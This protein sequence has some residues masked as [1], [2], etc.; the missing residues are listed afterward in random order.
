MTVKK[1]S[2]KAV[3]DLIADLAGHDPGWQHVGKHVLL[4][5]RFSRIARP[6]RLD[7]LRGGDAG[8]TG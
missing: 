4:A 3:A 2:N 5:H 7:H 6:G 8:P 1:L